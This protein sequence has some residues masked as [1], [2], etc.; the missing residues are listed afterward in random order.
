MKH[1]RI[2]TFPFLIAFLSF[3]VHSCSFMIP[4]LFL[5]VN[6]HNIENWVPSILTQN[7]WLIFM[8]MRQFFYFF[9]KKKKSKWPTQKKVIFQL[10]QFSIFF[11]ENFMDRSWCKGHWWGST[12]MVVRLS[13][14]RFETA[15]K[16]LFCVFRPF[17]SLCRT[18][19]R[20]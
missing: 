15:K 11:C 16:C 3:L 13:D 14:I 17:F 8:G 12:Y 7:L 4:A 2:S 6:H 18:A 10:C 9:L 1:N 5:A 20:P 19:S